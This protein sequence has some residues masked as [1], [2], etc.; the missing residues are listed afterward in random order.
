MHWLD[1]ILL[2]ALVIPTFIG[3]KQGL[4]KAVLS[5]VG[6]VIGVILA[7]SF[8]KQLAGILGFIDNPDIANVVAYV[9]ILVVILIIAAVA[10]KLL[11]TFIKVIMLGWVNT[12]G[13]AVFGFFIGM[14]FLG[15]IL[16]TW[17]K[18]FGPDMLTESFIAEFLL[19]TFPIV[20]GLLPQEFDVVRDFFN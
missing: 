20:L 8:Y 6:L 4:I 13:G 9:L 16:A 5:L 12:A 10:A 1:I 11:K 19:D 2:V 3:L 14:I 17:E 15:A 18:F 7:G